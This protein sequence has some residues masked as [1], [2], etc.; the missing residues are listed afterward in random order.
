MLTPPA[1]TWQESGLSPKQEQ[2]LAAMAIQ[3]TA[4]GDQAARLI[5][6][7]RLLPAAEAVCQQADKFR[8]IPALLEIQGQSGILPNTLPFGT[9]LKV[10]LEWIWQR[11]KARPLTLL[12][13]YLLIFLAASLSFGLKE[14]LSISGAG[15]MN[16]LNIVLSL[17][18]GALL[19]APFAFAVLLTR[20]IAERFPEVRHLKRLTAA[21]LTGGIFL[22]ISIFTYDVLVLTTVP[23]GFVYIA[24]C[25]LI[26]L[27]YALGGLK[28]SHLW[29]IG[30]AA[31]ATFT[32][33]LGSWVTYLRLASSSYA[34]SPMFYFKVSWSDMQILGAVLLFTLTTSVSGSL[35]DLTLKE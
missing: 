12:S 3:D 27:G 35:L 32:A 21:T 30:I 18:R 11:M 34:L 25:F 5:G 7:W 13:C 14:Y 20:L 19:G 26:A 4:S 24:A 17:E 8:Q 6:H 22:S 33:L 31:I 9:R 29:K 28:P 16:M 15:F 10:T 2:A 1:S 23:G